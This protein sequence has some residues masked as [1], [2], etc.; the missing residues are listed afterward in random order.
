MG[1]GIPSPKTHA[2][3]VGWEGVGVGGYVFGFPQQIFLQVRFYCS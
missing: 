2:L 3:V 1:G